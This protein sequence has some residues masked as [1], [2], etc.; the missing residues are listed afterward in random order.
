VLS[1]TD[2]T[3]G[4]NK[5]SSD[6]VQAPNGAGNIGADVVAPDAGGMVQQAG[7]HPDPRLQ[8]LDITPSW[9]KM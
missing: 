9:I 6:R 8:S 5:T 7:G 1:D 4:K 3:V 2:A